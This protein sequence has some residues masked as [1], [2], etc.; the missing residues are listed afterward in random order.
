MIN[1]ADYRDKTDAELV[2]L[3]LNNQEF[4]GVLIKRYEFK[5]IAYILRLSNIGH[6]EA[7]DILQNVFIKVYQNLNAYDSELKFSSWI[8]RITHNEVIS[9]Y[10]KNKARP[11]KVPL[12]DENNLVARLASDLDL[13]KEADK[14]FLKENI[15]KVLGSLEEKY[16]DILVLRFFEEKDYQE[17]SDI[18][19]KPMGT[20]ASLVNRAK[21]KFKEEFERQNIKL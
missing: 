7:E 18:L 9:H 12:E 6:E 20:I 13:E 11:E 15:V 4:F 8:Y 10:R 16:R 21:I 19:R 1:E 2:K 17:M 3:S 5:L 14:E